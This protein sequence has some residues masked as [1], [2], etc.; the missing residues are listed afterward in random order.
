M[1][2]TLIL[3][4]IDSSLLIT[5][6]TLLINLIVSFAI[7]Y[8]AAAFAPKINVLGVNSISGCS[9]TWLY[10]YITCKMLSN[11]RLYSWSLLTWT[12]K[13]ERGSTSTP[14]CSLIYFAR[15]TLFWYLMFMNSAWAFLSSTYTS[16]PLIFGRSVIQS[17]PTL[18][19]THSARRGF[20]WSKNLL[21]VIPFVLL[22]NFCGIIS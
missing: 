4:L 7:L 3:P 8:P 9:L 17:S 19:V 15:R 2:T 5:S 13:I 11:W 12:S 21:C 20:P 10:K 1:K 14:L 6:A 16:M 18:F 22:L